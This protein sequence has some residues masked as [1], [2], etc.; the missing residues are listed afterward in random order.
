MPGFFDDYDDSYEGGGA[1]VGAA[2]KAELINA[3]EP[4][5]VT[6]V[7]RQEEGKF[8]PKFFVNITLDGEPRTLTFTIGSVGSRDKMLAAMQEYLVLPES[9]APIC[10]LQKAGQAIL[11]RHYKE[12]D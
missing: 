5:P 6:G 7:S 3:G 9:E 12:T 8:G 4:F 10:Y 11:L 1:F 2:E